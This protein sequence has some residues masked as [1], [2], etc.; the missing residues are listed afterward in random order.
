MTMVRCQ[1]YSRSKLATME[2]KIKLVK[3][4]EAYIV[5]LDERPIGKAAKYRNP[6]YNA[7][8][9]KL[10]PYYYEAELSNGDKVMDYTKRDLEN[11]LNGYVKHHML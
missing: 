6:K 11:T 10:V 4:G 2:G 5:T 1:E 3:L 7:S 8:G 9:Q